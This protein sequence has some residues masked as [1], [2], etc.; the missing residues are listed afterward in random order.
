M[1]ASALQRGYERVDCNDMSSFLWYYRYVG[2]NFNSMVFTWKLFKDNQNDT[3][4][5]RSFTRIC[6]FLF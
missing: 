5:M 4:F 6:K 2:Q 3:K 1:L